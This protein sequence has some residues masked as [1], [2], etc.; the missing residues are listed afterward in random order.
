MARKVRSVDLEPSGGSAVVLETSEEVEDEGAE[1]T[2]RDR[3]DKEDLG[4]RGEGDAIEEGGRVL[5]GGR[6]S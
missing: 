4:F 1:F 6:D 2:E 3:D 5:R